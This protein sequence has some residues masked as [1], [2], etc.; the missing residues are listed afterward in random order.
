[1]KN[2]IK[3]WII[4]ITSTLISALICHLLYSIFLIDYFKLELGY[5]QWLAILTIAALIIPRKSLNDSNNDSKGP[6]IP[7]DIF[8]NGI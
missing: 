4:I 3:Q 6:K 7:Y 8:K 5:A 2:I 1:M